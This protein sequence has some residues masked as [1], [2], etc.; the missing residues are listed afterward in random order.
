M[1]LT[2]V[3]SSAHGRSESSPSNHME[4]RGNKVEIFKNVTV[5]AI[6]P[7]FID[8]QK[9]YQEIAILAG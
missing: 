7:S 3:A 8:G 4:A 1:A 2:P 5:L 9:R 6:C